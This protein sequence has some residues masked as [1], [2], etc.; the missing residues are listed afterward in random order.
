MEHL[1]QFDNFISLTKLVTF[2][3]C[4]CSIDWTH[5]MSNFDEPKNIT[6]SRL[7]EIPNSQVVQ[8]IL[9]IVY[10]LIHH[11]YHW[12]QNWCSCVTFKT[13][14]CRFGVQ[15]DKLGL[16][17]NFT[18][19]MEIISSHWIRINCYSFI[20]FQ[21]KLYCDLHSYSGIF[22]ILQLFFYLADNKT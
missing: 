8:S 13:M 19:Y 11:Y 5:L 12:H 15:N 4:G 17:T 22:P 6:R 2:Y 21:V 10:M 7:T 16:L 14:I 9:K 1:N 18:F 20:Y 3:M